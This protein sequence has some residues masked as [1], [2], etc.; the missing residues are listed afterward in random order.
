MGYVRRVSSIVAVAVAG[1]LL[2]VAGLVMLVTPGPGLL[3]IV[4]G[5]ALLAREFQWARRLL[6]RARRRVA[7]GIAQRRRDRDVVH[8]ITLP[9]TAPPDHPQGEDRRGE[10]V[11]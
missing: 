7:D 6:D 10:R 3:A 9:D 4:A 5:L 11:A 8:T 1:S 2:V